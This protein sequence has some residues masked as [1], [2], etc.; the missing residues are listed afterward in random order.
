MQRILRLGLMRQLRC[1]TA[2]P[3]NQQK[4]LVL[5]C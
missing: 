2:Y 5:S 4:L 1:T 3:D